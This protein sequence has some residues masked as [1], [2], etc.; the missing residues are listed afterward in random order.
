MH[1]VLDTNK[2]DSMNGEGEVV[3]L[4]LPRSVAETLFNALIG[5]PVESRPSRATMLRC[6]VI[7]ML[8]NGHVLVALDA[9]R[10]DVSLPEHLRGQSQAV[11]RIGYNLSPP[12][13]DLQIDA[14]GVAG[15]LMFGSTPW[16]CFVPWTSV[17][18]L[19]SGDP[20]V[21]PKKQSRAALSLVPPVEC[22][23]NDDEM[24]AGHVPGCLK[25]V[26]FGSVENTSQHSGPWGAA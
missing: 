11:L 2:G 18:G 8:Q 23:C 16:T 3:N 12:I 19:G 25:H 5:N 6:Q 7:S 14:M 20:I 1:E 24:L 13:H 17:L 22:S 15:T 26:T 21:L 4:Q 10:P 9:T